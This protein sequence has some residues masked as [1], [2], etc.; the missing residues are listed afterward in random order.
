M[1]ILTCGRR[2][3]VAFY[4]IGLNSSSIL[5]SALLTRA[6]I[7]STVTPSDL[8]STLGIYKS[9]HNIVIGS[10]VVCVAGLL[11]GYYATFF[12]IDFRLWPGGRKP[13]QYLGFV[14]LTGLLAILGKLTDHPSGVV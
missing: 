9:L 13:I 8:T 4:G 2:Q 5:T 6:G 14:M 1:L 3:Q 10:L 11:P 7:G 12:L